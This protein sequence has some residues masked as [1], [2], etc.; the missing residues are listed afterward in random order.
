MSS[1]NTAHLYFS[2]DFRERRSSAVYELHLSKQ[3][4]PPTD[5]QTDRQTNGRKDNQTGQ[6]KRQ[7]DRRTPM[8]SMRADIQTD[9]TDFYMTQ[10]DSRTTQTAKDREREV[11]T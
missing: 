4:I 8:S 3:G 6:T 11:K 2:L 10:N 5:R 1:I 9:R 7:T